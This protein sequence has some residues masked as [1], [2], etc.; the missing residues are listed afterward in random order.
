MNTA[1]TTD[2]PGTLV[3]D[4]ESDYY[5]FYAQRG[6]ELSV[7]ITDTENPVCSNPPPGPTVGCGDVTAQLDDAEGNEIDGSGNGSSASNG[8]TVPATFAHTID[9]TGTYYLIVSSEYLGSFPPVPYTL[10][11]NASPNVQW[12][13]PPPALPKCEV[14]KF[15]GANLNTVKRRIINNHCTVG[16]VSYRYNRVH[17]GTVIT[18]NRRAG[19]LLLNDS[20]INLIVSAGPKPKPKP[21]PKGRR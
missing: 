2:Y 21:K 5:V 13:A 7:S 18:M 17:R 14:P 12:I 3:T 8:I 6:T 20:P 1:S 11:V 4:N 10:T 19:N 9:S 15:V 16:R